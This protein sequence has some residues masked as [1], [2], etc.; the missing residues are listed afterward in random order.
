MACFFC[1]SDTASVCS[2]CG[3]R[4]CKVHLRLHNRG[5]ACHPWVVEKVEGVGRGLVASRR[6]LAGEVVLRDWPVVQGPLP[7]AGDTVC[8]ICLEAE[9]SVS[10]CSVCS[11]P[12]CVGR[13]KGCAAQHKAECEVLG[14]RAEKEQL[15]KD[16]LYTLVAVLRLLWQL[17]RDPSVR[18]QLEHLMDHQEEL[19][20]CTAKQRMINF[21][22]SRNHSSE[23]IWRALGLLQ[24]N[25]VTSLSV[26]GV[27]RAHGLYPVFSIT[28]HSCVANTRHGKEGDTFTL[29]AVV[30]IEKGQ[31]IT[32]N[33]KSTA[34]GSI[35]RR[36]AYRKLW[37]F[38]CSC[39]RCADPTELGTYSSALHC[40]AATQCP[41]YC[42]PTDR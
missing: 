42:L 6:V 9:D 8:I 4:S 1:Q 30:D 32:T 41:G 15:T 39:P 19:K 31:E 24:T 2:D 13:A 28:N 11:L 38:D 16:D 7:D 37:N 27:A 29:V 18:E 14:G 5:V 20:T 21:L 22:V 34:L 23:Q 10:S 33:Y 40:T 35:V 3:T 26:G 12:V 36:P 25:G 17:E